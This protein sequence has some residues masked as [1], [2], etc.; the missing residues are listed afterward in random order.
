MTPSASIGT[1]LSN[2]NLKSGSLREKPISG[3]ISHTKHNSREFIPHRQ[4]ARIL[5]VAKNIPSLSLID[6]LIE[7]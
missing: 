6:G 5:A 7:K 1:G 3:Y 4:D 2:Q